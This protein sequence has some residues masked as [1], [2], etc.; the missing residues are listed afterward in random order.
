[1]KKASSSRNQARRGA[2]RTTA[3]ATHQAEIAAGLERLAELK[4]K[5]ARAGSLISL[6]H[7][8]L[9]DDS[10]YDEQSWPKLK[11]ALEDERRR[12]GAR[13]LFDD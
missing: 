13:S 2:T 8:W 10:G 12:T 5:S 9:A 11:K 3:N 4:P 1:M 6:L 7:S